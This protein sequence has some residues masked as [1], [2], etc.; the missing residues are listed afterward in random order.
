MAPS[1]DEV[2][3]K[4]RDVLTDA[5]GVDDEEVTNLATLQGDLGAESIDFLD[6]VF[7]LEK[8][9]SIKIPKGELFPDDILNNPENVDGDRMTPTGLAKLKA[10]MPHADFS[11]FER[12][13]TVSKMPDLFTVDTI[14][15]YVEIKLQ[16]A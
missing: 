16:A 7:R 6:I 12:D 13:A 11:Q 2:F 1:R 10:A 9:F 5:L 3:E 8:A 4:V 14:V 15:N